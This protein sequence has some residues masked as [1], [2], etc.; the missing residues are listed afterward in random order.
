MSTERPILISWLAYNHDPYERG[1]DQQ[2]RLDENGQR[3]RGPTLTFL[4]DEE[5]PYKG[6]VGQLIMFAR[7]DERSVER[8]HQT[9]DEI[10]R[11]D[12]TIRCESRLWDGTD[13]TD[14]ERIFAFV[15]EQLK[16]IQ[17]EHRDAG[18]LIH[19]SPG[20]PS[21]ATIS[22]LMGTTGF[23]REPFVLLKSLRP[24]ERNGRG[25]VEP[26][27]ISIDT[28]YKRYQQSRPA[29]TSSEEQR[30]FWDP[31]SFRSDALIELY[32]NAARI[33][34][35]RAP[36]LLLGERGVGKTTLAS[37]VR[38]NSPFRQK[39]LDRSWP[40][41]A[42]GQ[43]QPET[44]RAE[45]FGYRKGAFTGA[46]ED[47]QGLLARANEDT[48]FLDEV[49]DLARD[50]Q[51]LLIKAIEERRFQPLGSTDWKQSRFRL[52]TATN[53]SL[54][55]LRKRLDPDF[56]DRVAL[57]RL[58]IPSVRE[59]PEDI[60]WLWRSVWER[61]ST[62][63]GV[64]LDLAEAH[65]HRVVSYLQGHPLPGNLRDLFAVAWRLLAHWDEAPSSEDALAAWLPS[66]LDP[67]KGDSTGNLARDVASRFAQGGSLDDLVTDAGPLPS[68]DVMRDMQTWMAH[69]IRRLARQRGVPQD[70]LI[71]VTA[72]TMREWIKAGG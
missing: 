42:C 39:K 72:K 46:T 58:R 20:T 65:H 18:L 7:N 21:M 50:S 5:S 9:F 8:M 11:L 22:V 33:A 13:P 25:A 62:E 37:W 51:R 64:G 67:V 1:R 45:L 71:D 35:L 16:Q 17:G 52:I 34:R 31:A 41:V 43:Y 15:R 24:H 27:R 54:G 30:L 38:L 44:I 47:R 12:S 66:S 49:G 10:R 6:K 60:P 40:A 19:T 32:D 4:F 55:D 48:L 63:A 26:I 61:V 23:I 70:S 59:L 14:H 53:V 56:F 28:F 3:T 57:L 36:V 68:K 29:E 2:P 69:E